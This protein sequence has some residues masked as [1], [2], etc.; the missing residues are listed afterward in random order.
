[1]FRSII[2]FKVKPGREDDFVSAFLEAGMLARPA[3]IDGFVSAELLRA[4]QGGAD[5]VVVAS[6]S[7]RDAYAAWRAVS[8][9]GAP[10]EALRRLGG[11]IDS[12]R[13]GRLFEVVR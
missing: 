10:Q 12:A 13:E 5:F 7:K 6:W 8:Q 2:E 11:C 3:E 1:M 4:T 9:S